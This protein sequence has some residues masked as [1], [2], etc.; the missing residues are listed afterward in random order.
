MTALIVTTFRIG[1]SAGKASTSVMT[2]D[3][4][5]LQRRARVLV[6]RDGL[7]NRSGLKVQSGSFRKSGEAKRIFAGKQLED[8]RT[9]ADYNIQKESTLHF[10]KQL[11]D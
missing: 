4:M 6:R 1:Q 2:K 7:V 10:G 5:L 9:M 3:R 8:G 11:E